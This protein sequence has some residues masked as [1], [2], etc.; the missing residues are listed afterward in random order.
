MSAQ[1]VAGS[2]WMDPANYLLECSL[3]VHLLSL[4]KKETSHTFAAENDL[5]RKFRPLCG[6][7]K[8]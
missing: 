2:L 5:P 7:D 1:S 6:L 3:L 8:A 4:D